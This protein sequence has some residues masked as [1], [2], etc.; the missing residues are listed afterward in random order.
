MNIV[1]IVTMVI[2]GLA[3]LGAAAWLWGEDSRGC[4]DPR[5]GGGHDPFRS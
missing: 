3:V 1:G 2:G 5:D 4:F